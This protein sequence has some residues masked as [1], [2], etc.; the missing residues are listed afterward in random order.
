VGEHRAVLEERLHQP[1]LGDHRAQRGVAGGDALGAG[2][3]VGL[4][5]E[6]LGA[7]HVAEPAEGTDDLVGHHEHVVLV[8]DLAHPL[9]V[10]GRRREAAAGVLHRLEEDGGDRVGTLVLDRHGDLVRG[11]SA[12]RLGVGPVQQP[13]GHLGG[14][15]GVG[16]GHPEGGGYERLELLLEQRQAGDREGALGGAVVGDGPAD[17]LVL[18]GLAG[19]LEV[20]L[21]QLPGRLHGL[22]ATA[23]E[24]DPVE[25]ARRVGG[26][27][28]GEL[29]GAGVG[30]GPQRHEGQLLGLLRR[31]VG[32]LGAPVAELGDE[33]ARQAVEVAPAVGVPDV[34]ALA[35]DDHRDVVVAVDAVAGEV[36]PQVVLGGTLEVGVGCGRFH[37]AMVA[38]ESLECKSP[39][40]DFVV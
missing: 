17:D 23:G 18:H 6:P 11:P 8:T 28:V 34:G 12:E 31:R 25:A 14:A 2:D 5:A 24:E 4:V 3:H 40:L 26:H 22:A 39:T 38:G 27:L 37:G 15:V 29:D 16:V 32:Q 7:E 20:V 13:A 9:E 10:A 21:G 35:L 1:V 30:V 36:Q 33:Q 19:E